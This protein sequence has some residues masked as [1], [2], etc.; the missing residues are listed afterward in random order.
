MGRERRRSREVIQRDVV[1]SGGSRTARDEHGR[2]KKEGLTIDGE[3]VEP[4]LREAAEAIGGSEREG[5]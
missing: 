1:T 2:G 5:Q 4:D 3:V